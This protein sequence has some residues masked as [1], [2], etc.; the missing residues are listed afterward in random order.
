MWLIEIEILRVDLLQA[1]SNFIYFNASCQGNQ[2]IE[3]A[4]N[5]VINFS[6]FPLPFCTKPKCPFI[7]VSWS[8]TGLVSC[9]INTTH[10][11]KIFLLHHNSRAWQLGEL[12]TSHIHKCQIKACKKAQLFS[13][14]LLR[15][16]S[17]LKGR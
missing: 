5:R 14:W 8:S 11:K 10:M 4:I 1:T 16:A 12:K 17:V 15:N 2:Q 3:S 13:N 7:S 6:Y 9:S